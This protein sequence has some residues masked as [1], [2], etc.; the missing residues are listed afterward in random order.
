[1]VAD[2]THPPSQ[3]TPPDTTPLPEYTFTIAPSLT[4][5]TVPPLS[6]LSSHPQYDALATGALVFWLDPSSEPHVPHIL[7]QKRSAHDSMPGRWETPGGGADADDAT[8]LHAAAREL[9]EESGLVATAV[10]AQVGGEQVFFSRRGMR[11]VKL[12]FEVEVEGGQGEEGPP[13]VTLDEDEHEEFVWATEEECK[14]GRKGGTELRFTTRAQ[15]E[16]VFEGFRRRD[17]R[18]E[19]KTG[20]GRRAEGED[21]VVELGGGDGQAGL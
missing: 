18:G 11:I 16:V 8:V 9:R 4:Q 14:A 10:V 15:R 2:S 5:F 3:P 1:M 21:G 19:G 12:S 20:E 13:V 17:A 7:L 6:Y